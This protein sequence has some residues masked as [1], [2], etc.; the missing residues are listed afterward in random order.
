MSV[1]RDL[2][3]VNSSVEYCVILEKASII[4]VERLEESSIRRNVMIVKGDSR[5]FVKLDVGTALK[6]SLSWAR[7]EDKMRAK[8]PRAS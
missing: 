6:Q 4:G 7:D 8:S 1:G 3:I 5:R 2:K